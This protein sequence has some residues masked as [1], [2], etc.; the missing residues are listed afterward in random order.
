ML[1]KTKMIAVA[2]A[3]LLASPAH[4]ALFVV[5]AKNNSSSGGIGLGTIGI[6]AGET[7]TVN[8]NPTDLW[9]A[10]ALPRWSN[11]NGLTGNL[12]A[13]GT[14]DSGALAGTL[15]GTNFGLYTQSGLSAP[16]G[17]LVGEI[18][19][20]YKLLGTSY[21]GLA[22]GS[23]TLRLYYWDSNNGDNTQFVT[24]D[25]SKVP[26]PATL[27]VVATILSMLTG[28]LL[29]RRRKAARI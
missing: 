25:V 3:M 17:A 26:E 7:L 9:N 29:M 28:I 5:D 19:G 21:S 27:G 15:I 12:L 24:A 10:G 8:V 2:A 4:A 1:K 22:W 14:D 20:T 13:T 16:Y 6:T 11:A 18:G 23:G